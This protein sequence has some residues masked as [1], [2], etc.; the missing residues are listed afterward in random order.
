MG[1]SCDR[2]LPVFEMLEVG[3]FHWCEGDVKSLRV[4]SGSPSA[5]RPV[6]GRVFV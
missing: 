6:G 2:I 1:F 3:V 4:A 5:V